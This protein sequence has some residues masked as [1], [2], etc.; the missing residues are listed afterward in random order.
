M[1]DRGFGKAQ[2]DYENREPK[3]GVSMEAHDNYDGW[4]AWANVCKVE[5]GEYAFEHFWN[6]LKDDY[7]ALLHPNDRSDEEP[8]GPLDSWENFLL[9]ILE[10]SR[11]RVLVE[12]FVDSNKDEFEQWA[13]D[14]WGDED[15]E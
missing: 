3:E 12:A 6:Q 10:P 9:E 11:R 8:G 2:S 13:Y 15:D 14:K 4:I 5:F 1:D 7:N